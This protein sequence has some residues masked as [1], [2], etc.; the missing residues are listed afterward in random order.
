MVEATYTWQEV[1]YS[2]YDSLISGL[3]GG[4]FC[5]F[6]TYTTPHIPYGKEGY[7]CESQYGFKDAHFPTL[8]AE[9]CGTPDG[10][11]SHKYYITIWKEMEE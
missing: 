9:A 3:D 2:V 10:Y 11:T 1:P 6:S 4:G 5:L 8:M 7:R